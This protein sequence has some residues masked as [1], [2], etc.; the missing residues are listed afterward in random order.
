VRA[1]TPSA[2]SP[3]VNSQHRPGANVIRINISPPI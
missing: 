3:R 2:A 1:I